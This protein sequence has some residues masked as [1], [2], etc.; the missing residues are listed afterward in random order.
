[1]AA[2]YVTVAEL[3]TNLGIGTLYSDSVVEEVCQAAE[4]LIKKQ[5]W[6]NKYPVVGSGIYSGKCY[7]VLST[8]G[9]FTAGQTV[10]TTG[11]GAKYN[12]SHTITATFPWTPGSGSFP[13]F[14]FFPFNGLNFPRGYSIIS[15]TASDHPDDE[16]YHLVVPYGTVE[17]SED[18]G[19]DAY[20]TTPLI[21]EAT[22][23]IAVDIWQARQTNNAGGISPDFSPSP[24]RMGASLTTRVSGLLAPY[25]NP[26]GM[27]G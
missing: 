26:R 10:V 7:L 23:M 15:Y 25:R 4:D 18:G 21:R 19:A 8:S 20:A 12:G 16:A 24:Y 6:F 2:T 14:T 9:S 3:R 11:V 22:M 17:G 1:M 5:L 27:L 13:Y